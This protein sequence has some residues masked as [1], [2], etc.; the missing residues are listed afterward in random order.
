MKIYWVVS[1][2]KH[3]NLPKKHNTVYLLEACNIQRF[4]YAF[5]Q[6]SSW[7]MVNKAINYV[8][9]KITK[10]LQDKEESFNHF[11]LHAR[12][13][14][15]NKVNIGKKIDLVPQP[16]PEGIF[17]S[18]NLKSLQEKYMHFLYFLLNLRLRDSTEPN[19]LWWSSFTKNSKGGIIS[20]FEGGILRRHRHFCF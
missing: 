4:L 16:Y 3:S 7:L 6:S 19:S 5:R 13:C 10:T 15:L 2:K 8:S 12:L 9:R 14:L 1:A 18:Y 20:S 11:P 17:R